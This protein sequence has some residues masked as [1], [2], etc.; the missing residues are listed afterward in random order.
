MIQIKPVLAEKYL[1]EC[2]GSLVFSEYIWQGLHVGKKCRC[3]LCDKELIISLP[4][5]QS[6]IE[7]YVFSPDSGV[8]RNLDGEE[9]MDNWYS[10]KLKSIAD[11]VRETVGMEINIFNEFD[12]VVILNTVDFKYGH[13]LLFLL[14]LQRII[15]ANINFGIIVIVQPMLKWLVPEKGIAEIWTV[16][17]GFSKLKNFYPDLSAKI[18]KQIERF[19]KVWL[20]KGHLIPTNKNIEIEEFTSIKPFDFLNVP[21]LPRITFIWREDPDRLWIRNFYLLKGFK[22][23][24]LSKVLLPIHYLRVVLI[25]NLLKKKLDKR[26][27]YSVTGLGK[28]GKLPSYIDDQ[29][30]HAFDNESEKRL[31]RIYSESILVFGVHGSS[32]LLP[33]AHAGMTISIM[34]SKRWGNFAEDILFNESDIRLATFQRRVMPMN[35]SIYDLK[36]IVY[37]MVSGRDYFI[38]KFMHSEDL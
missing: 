22:K 29:R 19:D 4:V 35:I 5:N 11:P 12:E 27:R 6:G 20:S 26:Y 17:L 34:P 32:M 13:S 24:M 1:C 28:F 23:L 14:N 7:P 16:N 25:F 21:E 8:V 37:D 15:R 2:N 9:V 36:D 38:T 30:I 18:N 3:L 31:C 33:S 10:E